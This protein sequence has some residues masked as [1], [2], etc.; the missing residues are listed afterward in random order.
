MKKKS[1]HFLRGMVVTILVFA[2]IVYCGM[3]VLGHIERFAGEAETETVRRAVRTAALT[4][5]AV[6]GYFPQKLSY[7]KDYYGLAYD[8]ETY[9]VSYYPFASNLIPD[10]YVLVKGDDSL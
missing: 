2:L 10:I 6:E 9:Q 3:S 8:E 4:C 7:L 1:S 5:Y